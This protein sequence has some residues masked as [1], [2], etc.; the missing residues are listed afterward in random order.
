MFDFDNVI[1]RKGSESVKWLA[2]ATKRSTRYPDVMPMW[3]ADMDF[4]APPPVVEAIRRRAAH[5]IYGYAALTDEFFGSYIDWMRVRYGLGVDREWLTFSPGVVPAVA[6]AVRAFTPRGG[7]VAIMPPVYHPFK[8]LIEANGRVAVEAPLALEKGHYAIDFAALDDALSRARLLVFCSPHN[9]VG[10]VW[11]EDELREVAR[12]AV[13]RGALVVSD[14]I[15]ADLVWTKG[16]FTSMLGLDKDLD[17]RLVATWAPSKTFNIAGL[18]ASY[19]VTPNAALRAALEDDREA[20]GLDSPNCVAVAAAVAAYREGGP[21]LDELLPYLK[22]N[23]DLIVSSLGASADSIKV[24]D[25][26][27]TYLAWMDFCGA[28]L[29]G[30]AGP[31]IVERA[32]LWLDAGTR[33]GTGGGGFA[34]M[35]FGCP[36]SAVAEACA[37]LGKAFG[38]RP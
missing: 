26:E 2:N 28:G 6:Q 18:Q 22:A 1:D 30:D 13:R 5:P 4:P 9:P 17:E 15:H 10:R 32:G 34:R 38:S 27:G 16:R 36:R 35:N 3:V 20:L 33:F 29:S 25:C 14:E 8:R 19:L 31:A 24:H 11:T 21:W 12:I 7:G 37:R 23:Y